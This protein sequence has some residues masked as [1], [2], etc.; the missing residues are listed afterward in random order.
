M[1]F[2]KTDA[3]HSLPQ[4]VTGGTHPA[5]LTAKIFEYLYKDKTAPTFSVPTGICE[6]EIDKNAL[7]NEYTATL[8]GADTAVGDKLKE[9]YTFDTVPR[10]YANYILPVLPE[11]FSVKKE[12]GYPV[13]S[14]TTRKNMEY[15]LLRGNTTI[16]KFSGNGM[17]A[18]YDDDEMDDEKAIYTLKV[19]AKQSAMSSNATLTTTAIY[20]KNK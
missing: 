12:D 13:I 2:A 10:E 9:Y 4:G 16:C 15:T 1:G 6:V 5:R 17:V 3:S 19:R 20:D 7:N 8:A 18:Q 14:F 11:D